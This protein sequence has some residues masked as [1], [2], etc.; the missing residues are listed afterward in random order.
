LLQEQWSEG[1]NDP[2]EFDSDNNVVRVRSDY[3]FKN[4]SSTTDSK[5]STPSKETPKK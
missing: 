5:E 1:K 3:D 2:P 4:A